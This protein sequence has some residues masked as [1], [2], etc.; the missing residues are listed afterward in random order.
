MYHC[1]TTYYTY[2][3]GAPM[4]YLHSY[5]HTV[6]KLNVCNQLRNGGDKILQYSCAMYIIRILLCIVCISEQ[7]M[8]SISL[9]SINA[10]ITTR[11]LRVK[12]LDDVFV[13]KNFVYTCCRWVS[14]LFF[15]LMRIDYLNRMILKTN[16]M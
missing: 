6:F 1:T 5:I 4:C 10:S 7:L 13:N 9:R 11:M 12:I 15:D 3:P 16:Y 8:S 14:Q 2:G